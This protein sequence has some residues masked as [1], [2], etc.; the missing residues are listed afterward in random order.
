VSREQG[1]ESERERQEK[2][3]KQIEAWPTTSLPG[4]CLWEGFADAAAFTGDCSCAR[5]WRT[6]SFHC[7]L[8]V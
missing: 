6:P 4:D 2:A 5:K 7:T 3:Q 1:P 8:K